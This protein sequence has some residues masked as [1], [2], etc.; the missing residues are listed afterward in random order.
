MFHCKST[1]QKLNTK[2]ST[3]AELVA[4]SDGLNQ[5][6]WAASLIESQGY[7]RH[8][9]SLCQDNQSCIKLVEKG[10][11][12]SELTRFIQLRYFWCTDLIRRGLL[13]VQYTPTESM[14][15]D[16]FTKPLQGSL[17]IRLRNAVLG[18]TSDN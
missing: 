4:I 18:I 11:S 8:P 1:G 3:E 14:I 16:Y 13:N 17:Y 6:L 9:V 15:A 10:R 7:A 2:S 12:T 5:P